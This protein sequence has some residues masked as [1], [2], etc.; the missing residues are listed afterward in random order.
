[1]LW[2]LLVLLTVIGGVAA[3]G[4]AAN[5]RRKALSGGG[6]APRALSAAGLPGMATAIDWGWSPKTATSSIPTD[7]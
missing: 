1:M 3:V 2:I 7:S 5:E 4:I 6:G